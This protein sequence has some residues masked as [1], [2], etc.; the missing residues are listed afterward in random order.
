M[1]K[2]QFIVE[3]AKYVQKYAPKYGIAVCSPII[4]QAC[5]ESAYG[6]SA[7]A[8]HHNYFGLKYRQNRVKCH[9]GFF[10]DG[11]SE[12]NLDGTYN[13]LPSST[14]WY[15]FENL[16]KG[17]EGYFQFIN[18]SNYANL[19]GVTDAYKYLELIK[20]DGYATSLNY[21]KN[22]YNVIIKWNLTKY[23][24]ITKEEEKKVKVAIDA[25]HGS[26]TAGKRTPDGYREHWINVKTAYYCEQLLQQH[27]VET[28]RIAWNDLNATDDS[29]VPLTTRQA[30]IK[31]A[32]CDYAV[33]MHANAYGSG[34]SYNSAEGVST[35]IHNQVSKRG[36]SQSMATFIQSELIKGTAQKNRGVVPQELAMCNCNAMNVKA[37]CLV[38]IAFMT[39]QREAELMKTDAFCK[40]QGEDVARGIL[41]YLNIPVQGSTT[42]VETVT[43]GGA[44]TKLTNP[45][46]NTNQNLVFTVGQKVKLQKGATYIGGKV[47]ANWVYN[48]TLYVRKIDGANITVSTLKIGAITGVVNATNLIKL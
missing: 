27:G 10:E 33:S 40:E 38:E 9:C 31:A 34:S 36:D 32:G 44:A 48:A 30:Q 28:V 5:L 11:G 47:P 2:E 22:V 23:D 6:T 25:G 20:Q 1:T 42:K 19:K 29:N 43:T 46:A 7:K 26:D 4:A 17:I 16:E 14:A 35:H 21:V 8:K 13:T 12:Q 3:V 15:A 45:I 37:A 41:K 39:N 24:T 18:I